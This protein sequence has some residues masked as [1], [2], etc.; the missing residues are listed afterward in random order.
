MDEFQ[1]RAEL[2]FD[3]RAVQRE[4]VPG[5]RVLV[6]LPHR[7]DSFEAK[8]QGPIKVLR[9]VNDTNYVMCTP[10]RRHQRRLCPVDMLKGFVDPSLGDSSGTPICLTRSCPQEEGKEEVAVASTLP[11]SSV[12]GGAGEW[13][14]ES[15]FGGGTGPFGRS[16]ALQLAHCFGPVPECL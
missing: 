15:R 14:R 6:L 16:A 4:F 1:S 13:G 12:G 9:K 10:G 5:D 3:R 2:R 7:G 8:F 11:T